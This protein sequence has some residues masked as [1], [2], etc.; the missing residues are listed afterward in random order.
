MKR[1]ISLF[2]FF[3]LLCPLLFSCK[4]DSPKSKTTYDYFNTVCTIHSYNGESASDFE[5]N[6]AKFITMLEKY[7][8]LFDI[9]FSY[10]GVSNVYTINEN[11]GKETVKVSSELI[12]FLLYSKEM[13]TLTNGKV[14]VAMGA[15]LKL[16]HNKRTESQISG[17][18]PSLPT[19][20]ELAEAAKHTNI[21]NLIIDKQ[22]STVYI[23]D[24]KMSLDV[25]AIAKGY[26]AQK[27]AEY[28]KEINVTG[29]VIDLGGNL[30]TI[31]KKAS[32]DGWITGVKNP[33]FNSESPYVAKIKIQDTSCVTSGDYERY[34][35]VGGQRYHHIIDPVTLYPATYYASVT[36]VTK[37]SALADTL[38]TALFCMNESDGR[39]LIGKLSGVE[40]MWVYHDGHTSATAGFEEILEN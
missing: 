11:A 10:S 14:N 38:S 20:E 33:S 9:Y 18:I 22:N 32:G 21:D 2:L 19:A 23:S 31:G 39:A 35:T 16:W 8:K 5:K 26:T 17:I 15:V 25:G 36:I 12:D 27:I 4:S 7:H 37:N 24:P 40:V 34:Y 30:C 3:V 28:F 1:A 29:Y 13:Y 6:A